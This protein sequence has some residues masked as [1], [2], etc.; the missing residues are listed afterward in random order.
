MWSFLLLFIVNP[1]TQCFWYQVTIFTPDNQCFWYQ[2][3]PDEYCDPKIKPLIFFHETTKFWH[4][5]QCQYF[6]TNNWLE[7]H[8]SGLWFKSS[9]CPF[10]FTRINAL[11]KHLIKKWWHTIELRLF[12]FLCRR[13]FINKRSLKNRMTKHTEGP[14]FY[15]DYEILLRC[16]VKTR[17]GRPRW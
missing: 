14:N 8:L 11:R 5:T 3:T 15:S 9:A 2:V 7:K 13:F 6:K 17:R 16:H 10:T 12:Y 1:D 4:S